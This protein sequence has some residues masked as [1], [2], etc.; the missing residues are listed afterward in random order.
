M[1]VLT[2][3]GLAAGWLLLCA[4]ALPAQFSTRE[5]A[6]GSAQRIGEVAPPWSTRGW[7][8]ST[9]L[10]VGQLRGK[11]VLLR[12]FHNNPTGAVALKELYDEFREKGLAVVGLYTPDP[13]PTQ[14][15]VAEVRDLALAQGF[16][17]PVGLDTRWE[18][19]NRYWLDR[20]DAQLT[21]AT[22]LIDREGRIR[23][24]QPDGL[25]DRR[26]SHR[27]L[28]KEYDKLRRKIEELLQTE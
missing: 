26:S 3:A 9:P 19:L 25:Y 15:S 10:D 8:N 2:T 16:E 12:F 1:N 20:A 6:D 4:A 13:M 28:R 21:A 5:L 23:Y 14:T 27:P 17:F 7:I 11:V 22:F 24:I 18:T